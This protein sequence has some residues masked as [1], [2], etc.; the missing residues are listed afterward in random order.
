M[1]QRV[2]PFGEGNFIYSGMYE[3]YHHLQLLFFSSVTH[4]LRILSRQLNDL[5]TNALKLNDCGSS[6]INFRRTILPQVILLLRLLGYAE[7]M[8]LNKLPV[9]EI[10]LK[11]GSCQPFFIPLNQAI[12]LEDDMIGTG[13][14]K[15]P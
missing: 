3:I 4:P 10:V 12:H 9:F 13:P 2:Y 8:R 5:R 11:A 7:R 1:D 15:V 14:V 6:Y